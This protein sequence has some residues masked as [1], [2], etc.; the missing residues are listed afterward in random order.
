MDFFNNF[1]IPLGTPLVY[2]LQPAAFGDRHA[3]AQLAQVGISV[4]PP[5]VRVN[6]LHPGLMQLLRPMLAEYITGRP[7]TSDPHRV[8][9]NI[10]G[11]I[12]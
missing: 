3:I 2:L 10:T 6:L 1:R 4:Q 12:E 9:I 11:L 7:Y 8:S 5:R